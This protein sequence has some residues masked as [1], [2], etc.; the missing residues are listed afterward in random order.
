MTLC[1]FCHKEIEVDVDSVATYYWPNSK[2]PCHKECKEVGVKQE[3]Y[4][5]QTLDA[6]CNDCGHFER[7][8]MANKGLNHKIWHGLCNKL[9]KDVKAYPNTWSGHECFT[10]RKDMML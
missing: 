10:H 3:A 2:N 1:R 5:C 9:D 4:S 8:K 7:G 6:D